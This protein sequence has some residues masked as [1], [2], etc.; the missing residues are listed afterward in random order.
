[1]TSKAIYGVS[2]TP[3][4]DGRYHYVYRIT[5]LVENKHYYGSRTS[6]KNPY[7]DL[8]SDYFGSLKTNSW[9]VDDQKHNPA[10]Y[11]YKI[12]K[13]FP[14]RKQALSLEITLHKIFDVKLHPSFYNTSNQLTSK[15]DITGTKL[16]DYVRE[17]QAAGKCGKLWFHDPLT[18]ISGKYFPGTEPLGWIKGRN[19]KDSTKLKKL[20]SGTNWYH[21][22]DTKQDALLRD[23]E[24]PDGWIKG[25]GWVADDDLKN[26]IAESVTRYF[27]E[28]PKA[29]ENLREQAKNQKRINN[30]FAK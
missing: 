11:R 8:G 12:I 6:K 22:P 25:R 15:F 3:G 20:T 26:K 29:K 17:K 27:K 2:A 10:H 23:N 24:V 16:P 18:Q 30:K 4:S 5:N 19:K 9:V 13:V 1:M 28:N 14:D 7:D 21:N